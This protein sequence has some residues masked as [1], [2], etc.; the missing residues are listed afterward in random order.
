MRSEA[1][2]RPAA[3]DSE[4]VHPGPTH[5]ATSAARTAMPAHSGEFAVEGVDS[6]DL[7]ADPRGGVDLRTTGDRRAVV[8]RVRARA[9]A[10]DQGCGTAACCL[11]PALGHRLGGDPDRLPVVSRNNVFLSAGNLVNLFEQSAVFIV[12]AMAQI[13]VLLLGEIDLSI[14]F[15]AA[16]GGVVAALLVQPDIDRPW[17]SAIVVALP[18]AG[19]AWGLIQGLL[20]TQLRLPAFI[21]TL[22]G[23]LLVGNGVLL[24]LLLAIGPFSGYPSP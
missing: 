12:L 7:T 1:Q 4:A 8:A 22:G 15:V 24:I 16:I 13:F 17:W 18:V 19:A 20:I 10:A 11:V 6:E 3:A 23:S 21:V 5:D 9:M 14:G 2:L